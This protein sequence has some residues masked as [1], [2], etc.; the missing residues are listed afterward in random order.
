MGA[1]TADECVAAVAW[2]AD[3][4]GPADD[5]A[6]LEALAQSRVV[7]LVVRDAGA[8]ERIASR[9]KFDLYVRGSHMV[10]RRGDAVVPSVGERVEYMVCALEAGLDPCTGG[11]A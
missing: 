4:V 1:L 9:L 11:G 7:W 6:S 2:I 5:L 8:A 10:L 3:L